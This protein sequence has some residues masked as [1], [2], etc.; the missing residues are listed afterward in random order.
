MNPLRS[1]TLLTIAALV[2]FFDIGWAPK[3]SDP[4]PWVT[5]GMG[6][7]LM[8]RAII[9]TPQ[10]PVVIFSGCFLAAAAVTSNHGIVS[11]N[12]PAWLL[13]VLVTGIC[14]AFWER[15]V[16]FFGGKEDPPP[17]VDSITGSSVG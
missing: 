7:V 5:A 12:S 14:Y 16:K 4:G 11:S 13:S 8:R 6:L 15:I 9:T 2:C 1:N 3:D 10:P 17:P